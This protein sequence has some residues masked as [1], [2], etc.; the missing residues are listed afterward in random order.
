MEAVTEEAPPSF[1]RGKQLLPFQADGVITAYDR[2]GHMFVWDCGTGKS[3]G[4][5]ALSVLCIQDDLIDFVLLICERNKRKEWVADFEEDTFLTTRL[6]HG[7]G[8]ERRLERLG[9]PQV[10]VTTYETAKADCA[11]LSGPRSYLP[12]YLLK[13][14]RNKRVLVIYDECAKLRNRS[15]ANYK[16][17]EFLLKTLRKWHPNTK[18][19]G[20][21]ATPLEKGYEVGFNQL[22]LLVPNY[23]PLIKDFENQCIRYRDTF[24]RPRYDPVGIEQFMKLTWPHITRKRKTDPDVIAQFP[25]LS[26]E[27]RFIEMAPA[28]RKF[29]EMAETLAFELT[30][31]GKADMGTW[32]LLRQIADHPASIIHSA[33]KENGSKFAKEIVDVLGEQHLR[34]LPSAKADELVHYLTTI[35]EQGSKAVVFTFF[36]QSVL[37]D[38]ERILIDA[39]L[40]VFTYHGGK[41]GAENE[42]S[43]EFF[44]SFEEGAVLLSSDGGARGINLPEATYVVEYESA[45]THAM[46][47][48]RRD[49]IHRINSALGPVTSMTFITEGTIEE[50]IFRGV[51]LRNE[52]HDVFAGDLD[53][54]E[55]FTSAADRHMILALAR[56]RYESRKK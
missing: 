30:D 33:T 23:M 2:P 4:A 19:V 55:E 15:S 35:T 29:Y 26:E 7:A 18:V 5:I 21:S 39:G 14:M 6:H 53:A 22:R 1:L 20:L 9:L 28:Q 46:R 17:H 41:T 44:K 16:T 13:A 34:S 47:I 11:K 3:V 24:G 45:L 56:E 12:G 42:L 48:Q 50:D 32:M 27:F 25:P 37:L 43:K 52:K 31:S 49:R 36:G 8:R 10:L 51:L 40:M 54:G 38:L